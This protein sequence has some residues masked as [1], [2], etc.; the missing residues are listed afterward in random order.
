MVPQVRFF[1]KPLHLD[2]DAS[3][4]PLNFFLFGIPWAAAPVE[5]WL[6]LILI[7]LL[8]ICSAL[9]SGSEVAY[10][11]ITHNDI[12]ELKK[13]NGKSKASKRVISLLSR[14]GY[15]LSTILITNNFINILII[16]LS[17]FL[18]SAILPEGKLPWVL[19]GILKVGVVT[20]FL[21]F[22]GEVSPKVYAKLYSLRLAKFMSRP[23]LFLRRIFWPFSSVLVNSSSL[24]EKR[25]AKTS[26]GNG[27]SAQEIDQAIELTFGQ[28]KEYEREVDILK[29]IIRFNHISVKQIMRSRLD[30]KSLDFNSDYSEVMSQVK[31][32]GYSRIPVFDEDF[33]N[34]TGI[35]HAKDILGHLNKED[36]F[37]WQALIRPNVMYVPESKKIS[38]LL[39]E[40]QEKRTHM[41]IVVDE[42]GGSSGLVTLEDVME[43][44]IGDIRDEFDT[45]RE[46]DYQRINNYTYTF[47]GKTLLKDISKLL[48][49]DMAVFDEI[50][51]ESDSVAGLLLESFG[52]IP[53]R[54]KKLTVN[55]YTFEVQATTR[56]R[57]ERVKLIL[58][59]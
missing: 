34:I 57:I 30:V 48:E 45:E 55:D 18:F 2:P 39:K 14:P 36:D 47:E 28:K 23:L 24:I 25:L 22:F 54:G 19:D 10:F 35:L 33:D 1:N 40:F 9:V 44:I 27:F 3:E 26:S 38:D 12:E 21:V 5:I 31:D 49:I 53:S 7:L 59:H 17:S 42:Y 51:G 52:Y 20:A 8:L 56:K 29:S 11:S 13:E 58:P 16:I 46:I 32:W 15:L 41:G 4:I 50:R 6:S 37:E 43:E